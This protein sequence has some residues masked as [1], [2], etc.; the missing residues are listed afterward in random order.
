[1]NIL[2]VLALTTA[3][4]LMIG[5]LWRSWGAGRPLLFILDDQIVGVM[6][7]AG[8]WAMRQDTIRNRA[9][10]SAGWGAAAGMLYGSFFNKLIMP[11]QETPGNWDIVI[12]TALIGI[13]LVVSIGGTLAAIMLPPN[14]KS[15]RVE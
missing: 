5:E 4:S 13:A 6:L 11:Q 10:F 9:L 1:M 3:L 15:E 2:R 8:V 14:M 12:L 7:L